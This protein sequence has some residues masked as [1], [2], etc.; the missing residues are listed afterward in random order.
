MLLFSV[1]IGIQFINN[2]TAETLGPIW[3]RTNIST[4]NEVEIV[5]PQNETYNVKSLLVNFTV[6]MGGTCF[7]FG[8]SLD[9]GDV[10]R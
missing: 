7:D 10:V 2:V 8:Y 9:E 5:H 1:L 3:L 6:V 4:G